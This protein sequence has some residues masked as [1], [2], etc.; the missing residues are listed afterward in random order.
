M[1]RDDVFIDLVTTCFD[2][3][4]VAY[5][6]RRGVEYGWARLSPG[7][8]PP[9]LVWPFP[10]A[11]TCWGGV[12]PAG[13]LSHARQVFDALLADMEQDRTPAA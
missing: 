5:I 12:F 3:G 9:W 8:V 6:E 11:W 1:S 10:D 13:D 7:A 2:V 4:E